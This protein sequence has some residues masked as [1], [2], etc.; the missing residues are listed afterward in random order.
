LLALLVEKKAYG[1]ARKLGEQAVFVAVNDGRV[2][3]SYAKSL[4]ELGD[5]RGALF[6]YES[7]ALCE[8]K[9]EDEARIQDA[10]AGLLEK[11]GK[12]TEA[13]AH[14][15]EADEARKA[16]KPAGKPGAEGDDEEDDE[17][18]DHEDPHGPAKPAGEKGREAAKPKGK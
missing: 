1:E 15:K 6:E 16:V 13:A 4:E 12:K 8:N 11:Q 17:D 5:A 10:F 14:R 3:A 2:H 18:H 9:P 7:A